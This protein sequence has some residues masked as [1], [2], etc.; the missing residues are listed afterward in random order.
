MAWSASVR[1]V[2]SRL[3]WL[4]PLAA[5]AF[6]RA[7]AAPNAAG[8]PADH[9]RFFETSVRPILQ[10][11]CTKCP[12]GEKTKAGL[13]LTSR[14]A[15]LAGGDTG[16]AAAPGKPAESLLIEAITYKNDKLQMPPSG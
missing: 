10:A 1:W 9:L 3:A 14:E 13:K 16:P 8:S 15:V 2:C 6:A 7:D 4:A 12:G 5:C 11:N